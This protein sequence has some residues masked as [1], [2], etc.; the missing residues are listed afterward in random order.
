LQ[1][2]TQPPCAENEALPALKPSQAAPM[3]SLQGGGA[4]SASQTTFP[5][6]ARQAHVPP[7]DASS[8]VSHTQPSCVWLGK[9]PAPSHSGG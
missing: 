9:L 3:A 8:S 4:S 5:D 2:Q 7:A 1:T 6:D